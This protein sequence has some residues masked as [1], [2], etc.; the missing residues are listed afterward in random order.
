MPH[1]TDLEPV[2]LEDVKAGKYYYSRIDSVYGVLSGYHY[3]D[4]VAGFLEVYDTED[5]DITNNFIL[6]DLSCLF[7]NALTKQLDEDSQELSL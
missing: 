2:R 7:T 5:E 4:G 3:A 1:P 6:V